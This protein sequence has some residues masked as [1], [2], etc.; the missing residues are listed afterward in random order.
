MGKIQLTLQQMRSI[1]EKAENKQ[2]QDNSFSDT[3]II[4]VL[5][6]TDYLTGGDEIVA[7]LVSGFQECNSYQIY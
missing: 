2:K 3:V 1:I 5:K 7:H 4:T 6:E